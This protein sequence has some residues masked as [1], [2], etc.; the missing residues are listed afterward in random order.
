M[1]IGVL[2]GGQLALMLASATKKMGLQ[3]LCFGPRGCPAHHVS[4]TTEDFQELLRH[5]QRLIIENEFLD[6]SMEDLLK[7]APLTPSLDVIALFSNKLEQKKQLTRLQLPTS[8]Y[9][10]KPPALS[11]EGWLP[12]IEAE[13]PAGAV[14]KWAKMGYDGHGTHFLKDKDSALVFINKAIDRQIP[15]YAEEKIDFEKELAQ[16]TAFSTLNKAFHH[17]PLVETQQMDGVCQSVYSFHNLQLSQLATTYA[18]KLALASG[19]FGTF[20]IE[21]FLK[22]GQLWINEIAPRVHNSGHWSQ[23][24]ALSQFEAHLRAVVGWPFPKVSYPSYF[25]MHNILGQRERLVNYKK[26]MVDQEGNPCVYWYGKKQIRPRRKLGHV[27]FVADNLEQMKVLDRLAQ[28]I[29]QQLA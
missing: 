9:I 26:E 13:F 15:L 5:S 16:V 29:S 6:S 11:A 10:E 28:Q 19:L 25:G 23:H 14:I 8:R 17:F 3:P 27:N 1:K 4:P 21:F 2:G 7:T 20:A 18:E 22:K 12:H 24:T